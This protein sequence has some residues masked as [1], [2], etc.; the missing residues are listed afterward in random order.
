MTTS[1]KNNEPVKK[2]DE[3]IDLGGYRSIAE[4][5]WH[6][7]RLTVQVHIPKKSEA[8]KFFLDLQKR[9]SK[10]T[11]VKISKTRVVMLALEHLMTVKET[12]D[13][14]LWNINVE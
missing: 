2:Q 12:K 3:K 9:W 1:K 8:G 6:N 13:N 11:G 7:E 14:P 5:D 10:A 4:K